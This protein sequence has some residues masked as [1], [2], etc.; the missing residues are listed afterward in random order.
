MKKNN[1]IG[2][3][4]GALLTPNKSSDDVEQ[5]NILI[6]KIIPNPNQPRKFFDEKSLK[7]LAQS[8]DEKGLITPITVKASNNK[9]IIVAGERRFRAHQLLKRKRILAYIIDADSNKDIMYMA[10]IENIQREDLNAIE[11]AKGY[12]YLKDNLD[13]SITEIAK[14]VGKSRPAVSNSLRLLNLPEEIQNSILK[15]EINAGQARA[16]LQKK[17]T[18]GMILLWRR[19]LKEKMSVRKVEAA[20]SNDIKWDNQISE[21]ENKIARIIG[22]KVTINNNKSTKKGFVKIHFDSKTWDRVVSKLKSIKS[23]FE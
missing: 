19:L 12:Q 8:I 15:N 5:N 3:G 9:Y 17:T 21:I 6:S 4:I 20:A 10:L 11:Q 16:I 1:Q 22:T 23:D 14:T 7:Q 18:Q 2:Q 13:S